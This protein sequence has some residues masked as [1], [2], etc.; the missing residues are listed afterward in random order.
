MPV[1]LTPKRDHLFLQIGPGSSR[2]E[3]LRTLNQTLV[4]INQAT[5]LERDQLSATSHLEEVALDWWNE[6]EP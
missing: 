3:L 6:A 1:H 4:L 5:Q 2:E